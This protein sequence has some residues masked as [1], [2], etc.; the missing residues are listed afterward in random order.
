MSTIYYI[1]FTNALDNNEQRQL[2]LNRRRVYVFTY[3]F[4]VH[5]RGLGYTYHYILLYRLRDQN[6]LQPRARKLF[7]Y[8]QP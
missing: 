6:G 2:Q 4:V 3:L 8:V 7:T 5:P 1:N